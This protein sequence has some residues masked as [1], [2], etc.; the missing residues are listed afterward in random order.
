[1]RNNSRNQFGKRLIILTNATYGCTLY[2]G[3]FH[4]RLIAKAI[5]KFKKTKALDASY[6]EDLEDMLMMIP[7]DTEFLVIK[8]AINWNPDPIRKILESF[9]GLNICLLADV[10]FED[11]GAI[12]FS[13]FPA[14]KEAGWV[15]L[16]LDLKME[17]GKQELDKFYSLMIYNAQFYLN[18]GLVGAAN[19]NCPGMAKLI[20]DTDREFIL[21]MQKSTKACVDYSWIQM[22]EGYNYGGA[23]VQRIDMRTFKQWIRRYAEFAHFNVIESMSIADETF[24]FEGADYN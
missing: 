12:Q 6:L 21:F 23:S 18:R 24:R 11:Q 9:P 3:E 20:E 19:M 22:L 13:A 14:K 15:K 10:P 7:F 5:E 4:N 16:L 17:I 2:E 1:M 8:N